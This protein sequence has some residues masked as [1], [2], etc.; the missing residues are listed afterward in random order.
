MQK[1]LSVCM[2]AAAASAQ[3]E[4]IAGN[5][6]GDFGDIAGVGNAKYSVD[7]TGAIGIMGVEY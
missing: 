2:L 1:S 3:F 6:S 7:I 4:V 5:A